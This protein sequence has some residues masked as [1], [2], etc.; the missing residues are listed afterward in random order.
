MSTKNDLAGIVG[1]DFVKDDS[2]TVAAYG[3][4]QSFVPPSVPDCVVFPEETS[5]VQEVLR[6]AN[7]NNT[8]VTLFNHTFSTSVAM[9]SKS[10]FFCLY[11]TAALA[12]WFK[13]IAK[14][15]ALA[16]NIIAIKYA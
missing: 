8:P 12:R 16:I 4:D 15:L 1:S 9:I 13:E 11:Y 3:R 5:Q 10:L 14:N 2:E 7:Q 6:L